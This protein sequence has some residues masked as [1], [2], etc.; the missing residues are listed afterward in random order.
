MEL[1]FTGIQGE[2]GSFVAF[3]DDRSLILGMQGLSCLVCFLGRVLGTAA[4]HARGR[5]REK[6]VPA[7]DLTGVTLL[8]EQDGL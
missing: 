3:E 8:S 6:E 5:C 7:E 1:P 4:G 2:G